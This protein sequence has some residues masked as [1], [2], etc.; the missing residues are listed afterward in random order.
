MRLLMPQGRQNSL[1]VAAVLALL[2]TGCSMFGGGGEPDTTA[3]TAST[4]STAEAGEGQI[5]VRRYLGP[6][7]CPELRIQD[8]TE[9]IRSYERGHED[10]PAYVV[11]QASIGRT[12]RE[13]LYDQQNNLTLRIGV[14]GRVIAGPKGGSGATVSVPLRIAIVK[15]REAT[16]ASESYPLSIAIPASNSTAFTEVR[17]ITVPSP[18]NHRDYIIYVGLAETE[19]ALLNPEEEAEE[20]AVAIVEEPLV[21]EE[22]A[23]PP[24]PAAPPPQPA[25]PRELPPPADFV[26]PN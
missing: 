20:P 10:D 14:S 16:L 19:D 18:G 17:E 1:C 3:T 12:A 23:P 8:G 7:Y 22:E 21:I 5:D 2:L 9:L 11:W 13:C 15:F 6:D 26:L 4:A 25:Q 24:A